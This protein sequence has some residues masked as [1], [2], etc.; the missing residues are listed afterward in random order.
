MHASI[1]RRPGVL[2]CKL[3][4]FL[5]SCRFGRDAR[6]KDLAV[7]GHLFVAAFM[8]HFASYMVIPAITD[9]T[10]DAVCPGRDECSVAIYLSGFQSAVS[11]AR[12]GLFKSH[13]AGGICENGTAFG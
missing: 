8:F 10:M 3:T 12:F 1:K 6:M 2:A 5:L 7:L 4:V 11:I 13:F 9:V